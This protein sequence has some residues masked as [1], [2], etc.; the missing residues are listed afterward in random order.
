LEPVAG[1][2]WNQWPDSIGMNG[3]FILESV[4]ELP[5]NMQQTLRA[6]VPRADN[7]TFY[8]YT[9]AELPKLLT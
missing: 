8:I 2:A 3:R 5:R 1:L 7:A 4:A 6:G 9:L